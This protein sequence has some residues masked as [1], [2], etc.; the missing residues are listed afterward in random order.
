MIS[1]LAF[2]AELTELAFEG[3]SLHSPVVAV[4]HVSVAGAFGS[5]DLF[6]LR[7]DDLALGSQSGPYKRKGHDFA[8]A[9]LLPFQLKLGRFPEKGGFAR[10]WH[11]E[12]TWKHRLNP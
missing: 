3:I 11:N 4:A 8:F 12:K 7:F 10:G 5:P 9:F 6:D 1:L 2:R